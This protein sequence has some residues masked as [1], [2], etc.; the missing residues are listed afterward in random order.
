VN[1]T[2]VSLNYLAQGQWM[3]ITVMSEDERYYRHQAE[4]AERHAHRAISDRDR[5]QLASH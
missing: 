3:S 4:F 1:G 5:G 2:S